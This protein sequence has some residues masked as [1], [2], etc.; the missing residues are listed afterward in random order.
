MEIAYVSLGSN[1]G[2]REAALRGAVSALARDAS[3][4]ISKLSSLYETDPVGPPPQGPY[5]NGAVALETTLPPIELLCLLQ[6]VESEAG[7]V[8]EGVPRWS[9]RS[10]DLDLLVYGL[11]TV[12][13]PAL[14]VPHP[15]MADRAFVLEPLSEIA[16]WLRHPP[17][18]EA[19]TELAAAVRDPK[20]VRPWHSESWDAFHS[21]LEALRT[22]GGSHGDR[23]GQHRA[24]G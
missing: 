3:V 17:T 11:Q 9:A 13:D 4:S 19:I 1:L 16:P 14:Q 10:L 24:G 5:L 18:R 7:R 21:E 2:D 12:D 20:A 15:R 6:Q 23:S 8:R 22:D